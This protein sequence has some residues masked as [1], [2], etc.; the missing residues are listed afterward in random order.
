[1]HL[2][3]R[4]SKSGINPKA[5]NRSISVLQSPRAKRIGGDTSGGINGTRHPE[6]GTQP[7]TAM[8]TGIGGTA[9]IWIYR[10][11]ASVPF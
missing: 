3:C 9:S 5:D 8:A 4:P 1:L 2:P 7:A 6:R 10:A 11:R